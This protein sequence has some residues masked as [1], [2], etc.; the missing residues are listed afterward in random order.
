M[1]ARSAEQRLWERV[2]KRMGADACWI[3]MGGCADNGY[4]SI[5]VGKRSVSVHRLMWQLPWRYSRRHA[6]LPQLPQPGLR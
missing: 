2:D 3:W 1:H 5:Q 4:G 6:G